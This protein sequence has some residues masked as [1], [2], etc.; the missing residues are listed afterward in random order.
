MTAKVQTLEARLEAEVAN[1][2]DLESQRDLAW[3]TYTMLARAEAEMMVATQSGGTE[4][5]VASQAVAPVEPT[6]PRKL[7]NAAVA[8]ALG[9]MLGVLGA[10]A[11]EWWQGDGNRETMEQGTEKTERERDREKG[12]QR[13]NK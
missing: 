7:F 6:S 2:Q 9:L 11:L 10:F 13:D 3:T 5:R 8:G 12:K 1:K 4:V